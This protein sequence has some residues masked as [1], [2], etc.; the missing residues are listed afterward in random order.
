MPFVQKRGITPSRTS[1]RRCDAAREPCPP[2]DHG[3]R[4]ACRVATNCSDFWTP[5]SNACT[6]QPMIC[7][8]KLLLYCYGAALRFC[9]CRLH[10]AF[11][12]RKQ[13]VSNNA[14]Y[15]VEMIYARLFC[16]SGEIHTKEF[17][18]LLVYKGC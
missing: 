5:S 17:R 16:A 2:D 10:F 6:I 12:I 3:K 9:G 13:R 18:L 11:I 7:S 4:I 15:A 8:N 14:S 1:F